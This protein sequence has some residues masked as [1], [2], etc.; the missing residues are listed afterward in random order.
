MTFPVFTKLFLYFIR[1]PPLPRFR[2]A[3]FD[4]CNFDDAPG[5]LSF[6][7]ISSLT[8]TPPSE[9]PADDPGR[10]VLFVF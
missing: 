6:L 8:V 7:A 1:D 3:C 5:F 10:Q 9:Y 4:L 2:S